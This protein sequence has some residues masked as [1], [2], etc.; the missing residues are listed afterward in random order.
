MMTMAARCPRLEEIAAFVDG[1]LHPEARRRIARHLDE[2]EACYEVFVGTVEILRDLAAEQAEE[3]G[4]PPGDGTAANPPAAPA[5]GFGKVLAFPPFGRR[6][7]RSNVF[8][9]AAS[10]V[11]VA[12]LGWFGR[13]FVS[14]PR[15]ETALP[16]TAA[17]AAGLAGW[18]EA[19]PL[20]RHRGD[21]VLD[22][23]DLR[24]AF[25]LGA[26]GMTLWAALETNQAAIA[27][28]A[29][30]DLRGVESNATLAGLPRT[31]LQDLENK[32]VA[33]AEPRSLE[34]ALTKVETLIERVL[35]EAGLLP[36]YQLGRWA[37]AG[38]LAALAEDSAYFRSRAFSAAARKLLE[39]PFDAETLETISHVTNAAAAGD[40]PA[41]LQKGFDQLLRAGA[42]E[43]R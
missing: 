37:E 16:R 26:Y 5:R 24:T 25:E 3:G 36:T 4:S 32:L 31:G 1:R 9:F 23:E 33:G 42:P 38:R 6:L 22:G 11:F 20:V 34:P 21:P 28:A 10:L 14:A 12:A 39:N 8:R 30:D 15:L 13:G 7:L 29:L 18:R 19:S 27:R 17:L 35:A 2:C 40:P 43:G 41:E